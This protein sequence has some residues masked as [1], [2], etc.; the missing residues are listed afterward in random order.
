[1]ST[2]KNEY[3]LPNEKL[4]H[5]A[6]YPKGFITLAQS[7]SVNFPPWE[8][9]KAQDSL[10]LGQ[11]LKERYDRDFFPIAW[12]QGTDDFACL[13]QG[14]VDK[15]VIVN[16]YTS[17]GREILSEYDSFWSWLRFVIDEMKNHL[18]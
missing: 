7:G 4:P 5:W 18:G 16:C 3:I 9:L 15:I 17:K 1:M 13:I 6:K 12:L 8:F 14:A 2:K 10:P 11:Q